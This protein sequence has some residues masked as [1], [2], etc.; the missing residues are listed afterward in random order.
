MKTN[1]N[2]KML[3]LARLMASRIRLSGAEFDNTEILRFVRKGAD[4]H[5]IVCAYWTGDQLVHRILGSEPEDDF[6]EGPYL[7]YFPAVSVAPE[8]I[9]HVFTPL[10]DAASALDQ[11]AISS[12]AALG[13]QFSTITRRIVQ[14]G[15]P[16]HTLLN[17]F[18]HASE[19]GRSD[20]IGRLMNLTVSG[21]VLV[22]RWSAAALL[23]A[24][25]SSMYM[26]LLMYGADLAYSRFPKA[27]VNEVADILASFS[28]SP[29]VPIRH[30]SGRLWSF[31]HSHP[32]HVG[33]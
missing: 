28:K 19:S 26:L 5:L 9:S 18:Q 6:L 22:Q 2:S 20:I 4:M 3:K 32:S 31:H 33:V 25:Q 30:K 16:V 15:L 12:Y 27:R 24:T 11:Q 29:V 14:H 8:Q 7:D 10:F 21:D 1:S 13:A 23:S 17:L